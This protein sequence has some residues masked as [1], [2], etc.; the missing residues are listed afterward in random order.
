M[1]ESEDEGHERLRPASMTP[2]DSRYA[3]LRDLVPEAFAEGELDLR[4]LATALGMASEPQSERYS[5]SWPGKHLASATRQERSIGT[6]RPDS[7]SGHGPPDAPDLVIEGDNLEVLKLLQKSYYNSVKMIYIDPPYNT[8]NQFIYPDN[9]REGLADYLQFTGQVDDNGRKLNANTETNGRYHSNWLSMMYPRLALARNLLTDGGVIFVTIDDNEVQNLRLIMDELFGP[10]N[11][12]ACCIWQKIY[13]P[14]SSTRHFS[15]DHDYILVYGRDAATWQPNLLARTVEQDSVYKNRDNDPRGRWRP[16]NLAARNYYSKGTYEIVCPGGRT[17]PGPPSGSYWRISKDRLEELDR[18][19]RVW[20]GKDGNNVPAPKIYLS[21]VKAGRVPQTLWKYDEV[22]H[23]QEAKKELLER[24]KFESSDS[25]Y[26]TPKPTRLIERMLRLSTQPDTSDIVLDFFAGSGTTGEAVW[27]LN[28]EDGGNRRFILVQFPEPTGHDDYATVADITR[29]RLA[30][31]AASLAAD[32][33][34]RLDATPELGFRS[35]RL[36]ESNFRLWDITP[37]MSDE[38]IEAALIRLV[39]NVREDATKPGM[40]IEL[41]LATGY[42]LTSQIEELTI[43]GKTVYSVN[44]DE[45]LI[46]LDDL[47]SVP[48]MDAMVA[49]A[50]SQILV[51]DK[52]FGG[53]VERKYNVM[54]TVRTANQTGKVDIATKVI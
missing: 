7:Q 3:A 16:N 47:I 34:D 14:K 19:G 50:P 25:V 2:M 8:G 17:I 43:E 33:A 18:E 38:E 35:Y 31:A 28:H 42:E 44:Q 6:L 4:K 39:D 13:A 51:L 20:W 12:I 46:F 22:G 15:D 54:Q 27:K 30:G 32:A 37:D 29:A 26:D 53:S 48:I 5:L 24:V 1:A 10:E 23:T 41:L 49:K 36:A 52:S 40:V 11:F 45:V 21:E 9:F